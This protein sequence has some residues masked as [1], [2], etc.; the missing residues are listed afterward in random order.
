MITLGIYDDALRTFNYK[1]FM[2]QSRGIGGYI[3]TGKHKI[4]NAITIE[5]ARARYTPPDIIH[6][7][8]RQM[9]IGYVIVYDIIRRWTA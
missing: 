6:K 5:I 1:H 9:I 7:K 3:T 4:I 8:R 2:R